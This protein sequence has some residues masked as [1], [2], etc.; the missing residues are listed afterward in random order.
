MHQQQTAFENIVGK[1]EIVLISNFSF[2]HNVFYSIRYYTPFVHIFD[3]ILLFTAESEEPKFGISGKGLNYSND[4]SFFCKVRKNYGNQH[5][6]LV[7]Q[8]S[9]KPFSLGLISQDRVLNCAER[10]VIQK[11]LSS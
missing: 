11:R 1:G 9:Q 10:C 2:S 5:F 3:I 8:S 7:P 4:L 6:L